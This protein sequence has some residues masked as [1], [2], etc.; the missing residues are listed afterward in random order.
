MKKDMIIIILRIIRA[1]T[2]LVSNSFNFSWNPSIYFG[3]QLKLKELLTSVVPAWVILIILIIII[4]IPFSPKGSG[5]AWWLMH[6]T[7]DPEVGGSSPTRV[8]PC[9]VLEQGTFTP[10]KYW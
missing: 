6:W 2:T 8:K 5:V 7:P 9:C 1:G 3:F 4:I 10:Q